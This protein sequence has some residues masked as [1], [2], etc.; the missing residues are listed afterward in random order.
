MTCLANS[1]FAFSA[2]FTATDSTCCGNGLATIVPQE[3]DRPSANRAGTFKNW[4][5]GEDEFVEEWLATS[6]ATT[7]EASGPVK[8]IFALSPWRTA[9]GKA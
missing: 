3:V 2:E 1:V 6:E 4:L 5:F 9:N 7:D 8:P